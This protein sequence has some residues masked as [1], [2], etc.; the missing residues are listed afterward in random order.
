MTPRLT[1]TSILVALLIGLLA[2]PAVAQEEPPRPGDIVADDITALECS[3]ATAL[4]FQQ[5]IPNDEAT[6]R[7]TALLPQPVEGI[8]DVEGLDDAGQQALVTAAFE[9]LKDID[10]TFANVCSIYTALVLGVVIEDEEPPVVDAVADEEPTVVAADVLAVTGFNAALIAL[11]G[12]V[13][14]G[15]GFL[16]IRRTRDESLS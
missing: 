7:L 6:A 4:R 13:L 9:A 3:F 14:L 1:A 15:L 5:E 11:I 12:V 8:I 2:L 10:Q 16:A